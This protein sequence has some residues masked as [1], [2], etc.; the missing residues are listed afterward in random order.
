MNH[1]KSNVESVNT[2]LNKITL[3]DLSKV[4]FSY[5]NPVISTNNFNDL[6]K[7]NASG[8]YQL[9]DLSGQFIAV[10][11]LSKKREKLYFMSS[12]KL[13]IEEIIKQAIDKALIKRESLATEYPCFR[14][15]DQ[16]HDYL[17]AIIIEKYDAIYT[18]T[19]T[20]E[21]M[22]IYIPT[23]K[24]ILIQKFKPQAIWL[25]NHHVS[26]VKDNAELS[27][28]ML[29]GNLPDSNIFITENDNIFNYDLE[30]TSLYPLDKRFLRRHLNSYLEDKKTDALLINVQVSF[31][32]SKK[33]T[34]LKDK[35]DSI[36]EKQQS[37][38]DINIA[39][40]NSTKNYGFIAL[41]IPFIPITDK[42][43]TAL[44]HLFLNLLKRMATDCDL[45]LECYQWQKI[46]SLLR[47]AVK[48]SGRNLHVLDTKAPEIDFANTNNPLSYVHCQLQN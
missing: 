7:K 46:K 20:L 17:P 45:I 16:Y 18:L 22:D 29:Y 6:L 33:H 3:P 19:S 4:E 12:E 27:D 8:I 47:L 11:F 2:P 26:R 23:L 14:L 44:V 1:K 41:S 37:F 15:I 48:K 31:H 10:V 28:T 13:E 40:R 24:D 34:S 30:N 5:S 25:K 9:F 35:I 32:L 43:R 42:N 36:N 21:A 38:T 39:L